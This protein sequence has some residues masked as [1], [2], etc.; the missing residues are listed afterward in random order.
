MTTRA[1]LSDATQIRGGNTPRTRRR[2]RLLAALIKAKKRLMETHPSSKFAPTNWD[3]RHLTLPNRNNKTFLAIGKQDSNRQLETIRNGR[4]PFEFNQMTFSNRPKNADPA[5]IGVLSDQRES[6]ALSSVIWRQI[7][8]P[9]HWEQVKGSRAA[10]AKPSADKP[11]ASAT[12]GD[13]RPRS[14]AKDK[15]PA[16]LLRQGSGGRPGCQRYKRQRQLV[17]TLCPRWRTKDGAGDGP[18]L[19]YGL[20]DFFSFFSRAFCMA[21]TS[22]AMELAMRVLLLRSFTT[23]PLTPSEPPPST[24]T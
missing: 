6:K 8:P 12:F 11:D 19:L 23:C 1:T 5:R 15:T 4:N 9:V 20:A 2:S 21:A 14:N 13:G 17:P 16:A 18:A 22:A 3:H 7:N 24:S 10:F